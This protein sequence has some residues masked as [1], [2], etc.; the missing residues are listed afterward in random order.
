VGKDQTSQVSD[1]QPLVPSARTNL[2]IG[3]LFGR[4]A[5][6]D[7]EMK[8]AAAAGESRAILKRIERLGLRH[9]ITSRCTTLVAV[10]DEPSVDPRQPRRRQR[11]AVEMPAGLNPEAVGYG[12]MAQVHFCSSAPASAFGPCAAPPDAYVGMAEAPPSFLRATL[13]EEFLH[14]LRSSLGVRSSQKRPPSGIHARCVRTEG[15]LLVIE[16]E[17]PYDGFELPG[18]VLAMFAFTEDGSKLELAMDTDLGTFPGPHQRGL[19]L[20]LALRRVD[21]SPWTPGGVCLAPRPGAVDP[22]SWWGRGSSIIVDV[23]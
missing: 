20:R 2:P 5:I 1:G 4:E 16:F 3:A 17:S 19:T 12:A 23:T 10:A 14:P 7:E 21:G 6:E 8:L 18:H 9:R 15:D 22:E 11:L 13:R